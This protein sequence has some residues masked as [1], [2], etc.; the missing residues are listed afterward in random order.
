MGA[1]SS[2]RQRKTGTMESAK[3]ISTAVTM[4]FSVGREL[5]GM[6]FLG[7]MGICVEKLALEIQIL[8]MIRVLIQ[9]DLGGR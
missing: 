7:G 3:T 5:V 9:R 6:F 2:P 1:T 8:S 4:T